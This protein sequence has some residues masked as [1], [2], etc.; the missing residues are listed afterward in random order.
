MSTGNKW[1]KNTSGVTKTWVGQEITNNSYHNIVPQSETQWSNDSTLLT[2]VGS[3]DATVAK[4]NSG[5]NDIS[6]VAIAINYLKGVPLDTIAKLKGIRDS[7]GMRARL[8]CIANQTV[9]QN[10]T[11]SIDWTIPQLQWPTGTNRKSYFDGLQYYLA[12]GELGDSCT[13]HIVDTDGSGVTNGL[14]S[15]ATFDA[16][17]DVNGEYL[18]EEFAKDWSL[19]PDVLE[20]IL[21]YKARLYPGLTIRTKITSVG[22]TTDPFIII[23]IFRHLDE[24]S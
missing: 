19:A 8:A 22:T 18:V 23:N 16:I 4:D 1:I 5:T 13:F 15:Q 10:T 11:T 7:N 24:T 3:G 6:D 2:D 12:N 14:Y 20:D 17:K 9:T 21:L